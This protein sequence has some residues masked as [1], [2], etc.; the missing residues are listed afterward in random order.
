MRSDVQGYYASICFDVLMRIIG[1]YVT[2][3]ILKYPCS[4]AEALQPMEKLTEVWPDYNR[5]F[6][7][8]CAKFSA[9]MF[10]LFMWESAVPHH[11]CGRCWLVFISTHKR[12]MKRSAL[13]RTNAGPTILTHPNTAPLSFFPIFKQ[14]NFR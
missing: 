14:I 10:S 13:T 1:S 9:C 12:S 2:H 8:I 3:P 6:F 11:G 4:N 7:N 5:G